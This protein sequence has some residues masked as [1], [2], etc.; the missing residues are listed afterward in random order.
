MA[1]RCTGEEVAM[2]TELDTTADE[3]SFE[4]RARTE[5]EKRF[6]RLVGVSTTNLCTHCGWC[7]DSC[8]VY[9]ATGDPRLSPVAKA[10]QVRS[11]YK[12]S[13]D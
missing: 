3:I 8:Y 4:E 9:L 12:R 5:L 10:D 6:S 2:A 11:H 7:I 13:H 1:G